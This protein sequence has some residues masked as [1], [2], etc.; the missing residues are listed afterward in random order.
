MSLIENFRFSQASLQDFTDCRRRFQLRYLQHVVWPAVESE[1]ILENER[2]LQQGARFHRMIQQ[3][4]LGV[5]AERLSG[6][7]RDDD[8]A[9]WWENYLVFA[10]QLD[11]HLEEAMLSPELAL[12]A[13]LGDHSLVAKCDL[14][15]VDSEGRAIIYDWKTSRKR[16]QRRWLE[17]RLQTRVYPYLLVRSGAHL[18]RG[19]P[20]LPEQIEMVYWFAG[21]PGQPERFP[22]SQAQY[23]ADESYLLGLVETIER[24]GEADFP[25]TD[26]ARACR[27]CVY[28]SLCDRGVEA[29]SFKEQEDVALEESA[30]SLDFEIDFDQIAEVEF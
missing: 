16:S 26:D 27:Y 15:V 19:E 21:Y 11:A 30:Q 1:P 7:A 3:H 8:L 23:Q 17:S 12:T 25:L 28:R 9:R 14:V 5:P 6:L 20:F 18:N 29:G 10:P 22:Y 13:S 2:F 4:L 24:L